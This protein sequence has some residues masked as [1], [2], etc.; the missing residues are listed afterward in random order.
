MFMATF[1][2]GFSYTQTFTESELQ[3][4]IDAMMPLEKQTSFMT[5]IV[6]HPKLDFLDASDELS[7]KANIKVLAFG[8]LLGN[9][10]AT[11][12]GSISYDPEQGTFHLQNPKVL[13]LHIDGLADAYQA[14][15]KQVAQLA[16]SNA[17]AEFPIYKLQGDNLQHKLA[18]SSLESVTIQKGKLLVKLSVF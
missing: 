8:E 7:V 2:Y 16:I 5:V 4:A 18:K 9:G 6:A 13:A 11:I 12:S 1:S 15:I 17:M 3:A 10:R 14:Q